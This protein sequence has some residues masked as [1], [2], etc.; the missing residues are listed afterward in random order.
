MF[1]YYSV[2]RT[3]HWMWTKTAIFRCVRASFHQ[4]LISSSF[5]SASISAA[6]NW[7]H[8][9]E[10]FYWG[11]LQNS[12]EGTQVR[13]KSDKNIGHFTLGLRC[14]YIFNSIAKYISARQQCKGNALLRFLDNTE[15]FCIVISYI[16]YFTNNSKVTHCCFYMTTVV[17]R[18][19]CSITL[20]EQLSPCFKRLILEQSSQICFMVCC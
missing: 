3:K 15:H 11:H 10:I 9:C 17:T 7:I 2:N 13:L 6:Q 16:Y 18:T 1:S 19:R 14:F 20:Y 8:F 5:L 12:V 4:D